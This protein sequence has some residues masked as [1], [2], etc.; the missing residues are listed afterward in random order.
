[1]QELLD[2]LSYRRPAFSRHEQKFIRRFLEPLG[3]RPD[4][5]GNMILK[6]GE[7]AVLWSSH[8]DTV[9]SQSG[10]QEVLATDDGFAYVPNSDC[11]G[12]DCTT[13]VWIMMEMIRAKVPGLYIFHRAEE[14]GG[15]GSSHIA[16]KTPHLLKGIDYAIAFDRKDVGSVIT[17][18]FGTRCASDAFAASFAAVVDLPM[19]ADDGGTFTDT[20][21]YTDL[22][23]ECTNVSVGYYKQHTRQEYQDL[24]FAMALRDAMIVFD[25]SRL[26]KQREAGEPDLDWSRDDY[27]TL[28]WRRAVSYTDDYGPGKDKTDKLADLERM[29]RY[30][31][32][33]A[34]Q[35]LADY[36]VSADEVLEAGCGEGDTY[37]RRYAA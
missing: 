8:T 16:A 1:M 13:G 36:G 24:E 37:G 31:P 33:A 4:A 6:V 29:V 22:I 9:H 10:R 25:E 21:N 19:K 12:A 14:T 26:V 20:A 18:Q 17:H 23:G 2:M 35:I 28:N 32:A 7:S 34:A 5:F 3:C 15:G 27:S 11:L 30:Y